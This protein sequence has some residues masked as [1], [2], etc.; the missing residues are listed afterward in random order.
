MIRRLLAIDDDLTP[1]VLMID[2]ANRA[3]IERYAGEFLECCEPGAPA[4]LS[5]ECGPLAL[6][7]QLRIIMTICDDGDIAPLTAKTLDRA[8]MIR[9]DPVSAKTP[10]DHK[11]SAIPIRTEAV[12]A[13]A[14]NKMFDCARDVPAELTHQLNALREKMSDYGISISRRTVADINRYLAAVLPMTRRDPMDTL[15]LAFAQRAL[16]AILT[17][18]N[19]TALHALQELLVGFPKCQ[20]LMTQPLPLPPL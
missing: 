10:I 13:A 16:P 20:T 18:A 15:D 9:L 8:F 11:M 4:V 17:S 5:T 6:S 1:T 19:L 14:F 2:D 12:S 3:P 7:S